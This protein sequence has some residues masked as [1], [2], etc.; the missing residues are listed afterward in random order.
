MAS[1][2]IHDILVHFGPAVDI[3]STYERTGIVRRSVVAR[4]DPFDSRIELSSCGSSRIPDRVRELVTKRPSDRP[5]VRSFAR[6]SQ[7]C[8]AQEI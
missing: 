5:S 8:W 2:L 3:S 7:F 4:S 6:R 1:L